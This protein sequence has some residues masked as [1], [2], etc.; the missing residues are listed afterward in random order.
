MKIEDLGLAASA[1]ELLAEQ[2]I[3]KL[4]PPQAD[5][6]KA[7]LLEGQNIMV[8]APTA[9]GKTLIAMLAMIRFLSTKEGKIVYLTPLRALAA[10]KFSE[11]KKLEKIDSG[12]KIRIAISTGDFDSVDKESETADVVVLTNEK[13][14]S[15]IRHGVDWIYKIGLVVADEVHLIG[16]KDRGPTLEVI[17]TKLKELAPKPQILGLSATITNSKELAEWLGCNLVLSDWRPVPLTEGVFDGGTVLWNNG[18][19]NEVESSIRGSPIDLCLDTIKNGGNHLS[20]QK[21][22]PDQHLLQQRDL[23]RC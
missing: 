2:K 7:G 4:Y 23:M 12:K 20:L 15:L 3:T 10:E 13:M 21:Q 11:F 5:A 16:D 17:L 1:Q 9:S 14:D 18:N 22:E 8:A 6:V 19:A